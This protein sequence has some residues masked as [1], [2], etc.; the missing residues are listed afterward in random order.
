MDFRYNRMNST[1]NDSAARSHAVLS[2]ETA[3]SLAS[4]SS[5]LHRPVEGK[6]E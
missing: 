2:G 5:W 6:Y 4:R 3:I 1:L